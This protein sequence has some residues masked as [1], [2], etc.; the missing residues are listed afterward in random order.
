MPRVPKPQVPDGCF[1]TLG[2]FVVIVRTIRLLV[3]GVYVRLR[4]PDFLATTSSLSKPYPWRP[5][6]NM[7]R[8]WAYLLFK[9]YRAV[10]Y[11]VC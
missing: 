1:G 8:Y 10:D 11:A 2:V 4:A 9:G 6:Q 7:F 5:E 3:F